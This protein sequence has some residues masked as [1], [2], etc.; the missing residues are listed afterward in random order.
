[1]AQN[2]PLK[3]H[4]KYVTEGRG[5]KE[6]FLK[7]DKALY[8]CIQSVLLRYNTFVTK[9]QKDGFKINTYNP[10]VVNKVINGSQ[11]AIYWYVYHTKI[12]HKDT[13]VVDQIVESLE[14]NFENKSK[15]R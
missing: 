6:I 8:G 4:N 12:S 1:M 14:G 13:K 2:V 9:L 3:I 10:C 11:C 15:K 5:R 7:L